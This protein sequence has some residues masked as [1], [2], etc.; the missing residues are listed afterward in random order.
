MLKSKFIEVKN[1]KKKIYSI[2]FLGM[3][4]LLLDDTLLSE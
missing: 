3:L 4:T 2:L 1:V